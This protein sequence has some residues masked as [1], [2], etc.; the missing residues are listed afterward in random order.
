MCICAC[1]FE[2]GEYICMSLTM[3]V[4]TRFLNMC[5]RERVRL[6]YALIIFILVVVYDSNVKYVMLCFSEEAWLY[7]RKSGLV[8]IWRSEDGDKCM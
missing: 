7:N 4:R 6:L 1:V 5:A 8:C 3:F 2:G